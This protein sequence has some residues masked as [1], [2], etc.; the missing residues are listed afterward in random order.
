VGDAPNEEIRY[1]SPPGAL[2][3]SLLFQYL[4]SVALVGSTSNDRQM[5]DTWRADDTGLQAVA[6]STRPE[7]RKACPQRPRGRAFDLVLSALEHPHAQMMPSDAITGT[8]R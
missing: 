8:E 5:F 1:T 2:A 4:G 6:V 7:G 3:K